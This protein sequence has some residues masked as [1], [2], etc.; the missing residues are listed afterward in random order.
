MV[1][2]ERKIAVE[3]NG[4]YWYSEQF[5]KGKEYRHSKWEALRKIGYQLIQI[6]EDD[7]KRSPKI[8]KS[9]LLHKLGKSDSTKIFARKTTATKISRT[10]AVNFLDA[11]HIQGSP[12]ASQFYGLRDETNSLCAVIAVRKDGKMIDVVRYATSGNVVGGFTKL[13]RFVEISLNPSGFVTFSDHC[14]SDGGLYASTGFVVDKELPPDYHYLVNNKREHK[15]NYR[16]KRFRE[17]PSLKWEEG[18]SERELAI[19]NGIHRIWDAGKI[20]WVKML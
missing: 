7:W 8:V 14:V 19:L 2:H 12:P 5:S 16:L 18:L 20:R 9:M 3:Y 4:L 6:W 17:D 11:Y 15:A 13:L 10:E 1:I